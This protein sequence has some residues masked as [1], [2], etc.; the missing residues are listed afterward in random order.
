MRARHRAWRAD[1]FLPVPQLEGRGDADPRDPGF[2]TL[3]Q[4]SG[5]RV[6]AMGNEIE[7]YEK[8]IQTIEDQE[9]GGLIMWIPAGLVYIVAGL[10]LFAGWLREA[11]KNSIRLQQHS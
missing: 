2:L 11:E 6:D 1:F 4:A 5:K 10:A 8:E 3:V 7:R 9:L